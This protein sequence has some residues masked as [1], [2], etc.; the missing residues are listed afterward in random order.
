VRFEVST[1]PVEVRQLRKH[2]QKTF[3]EGRIG[4][5]FSYGMGKCVLGLD[6]HVALVEDED[7][8]FVTRWQQND[9]E[10]YCAVQIK[11]LPPVHLNDGLQGR[12]PRTACEIHAA[13]RHGSVRLFESASYAGLSRRRDSYNGLQGTMAYR[14]SIPGPR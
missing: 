11:E 1:L 9:E 10:R 12:N 13:I 14:R 5:L 4:A 8:D 3:R 7:Y 6:V 2:G